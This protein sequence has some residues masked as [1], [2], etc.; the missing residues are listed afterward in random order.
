M[1]AI[2]KY[3]D[4]SEK[5]KVGDID[6][7]AG[8]KAGVSEEERFILTYFADIEGQTILYLRDL[9]HT[10]VIG[11]PDTIAFLSMWNYEEY[12]HGQALSRLLAECGHPLEKDRIARVRGKA[13]LKET[14]NAWGATLLSKIF[15]RQFPAV[16]MTWGAINELSTLRGYERLETLSS[17]PVL[18]LLCRRIAKQERR[19]FAWYY[20][21][22]RERLEKSKTA[23]R[24]T[25]FL[26]KH[27]WSPVGAGV[28][29]DEEVLTLTRLI[30]EG[31]GGAKIIEGIDGRIAGLPGL[32]DLKLLTAYL[33]RPS[34]S[35]LLSLTH[36]FNH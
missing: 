17:N 27:F 20:N 25:R 16:F 4:H 31:E 14:L 29:T 10:D 2:E 13:S 7:E 6:W 12:F 28:K 35:P 18:K 19:H 24:I 11:D 15:K 26:L 36:R 30:F 22:A 3:L 33:G 1:A 21:S 32:E 8:R 5:L 23:R 34:P 9:L